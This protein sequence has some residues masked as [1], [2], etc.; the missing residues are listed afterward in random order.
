MRSGVCCEYMPACEPWA[1]A[2]NVCLS[3]F[4]RRTLWVCA[5]CVLQAKL[6]ALSFTD[7]SLLDSLLNL[8]A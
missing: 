8:D 4:C 2:V 5:E 1:C 3:V 6:H 7:I